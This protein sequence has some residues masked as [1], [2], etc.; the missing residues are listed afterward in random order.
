MFSGHFVVTDSQ[1]KWVRDTAVVNL[2]SFLDQI[3]QLLYKIKSA[4]DNDEFQ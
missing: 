1:S 3:K 4:L 2:A